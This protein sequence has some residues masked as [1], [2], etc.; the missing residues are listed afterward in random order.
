M[1]AQ[2]ANTESDLTESDIEACAKAKGM[3]VEECK[4]LC[5]KVC[6]NKVASA[7]QAE[8]LSASASADLSEGT[9]TKKEC[10]K[11]CGKK[12]ASAG[13]G[14]LSAES[15]SELIESTSNKKKCNKPCAKK[16]I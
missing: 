15:N 7:D 12:S 6:T 11:V 1:Q 3:T 9:L 8:V 16:A 2:T 10:K 13:Q 4:A 5:K 14:V